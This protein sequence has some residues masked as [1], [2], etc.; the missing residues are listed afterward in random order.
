MMYVSHDKTRQIDVKSIDYEEVTIKTVVQPFFSNMPQKQSLS[1]Y[2]PTYHMCNGIT[3]RHENFKDI[4]LLPFQDYV[5][6]CLNLVGRTLTKKDVSLDSR[7]IRKKY[8]RPCSILYNPYIK[9][10]IVYDSEGIKNHATL[11]VEA[12]MWAIMCDRPTYSP[13]MRYNDNFNHILVPFIS[14]LLRID[15][16]T[17]QMIMTY[18]NSTNYSE[19]DCY[20]EPFHYMNFSLDARYSGYKSVE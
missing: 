11:Y 14:E 3:M 18:I 15:V 10:F 13:S 1:V 2:E 12:G 8:N 9:Q 7:I 17:T 5:K 6:D 4:N 19:Y 20:P 16:N